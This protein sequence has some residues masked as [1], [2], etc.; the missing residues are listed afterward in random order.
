M[1]ITFMKHLLSEQYDPKEIYIRSTDTSE[2]ISSVLA[3]LAGMFPGQGKSIWDKDLLL[4]TFPIHI[5]PEESD[6]ILGQKKSCPTYEESL[7]ILKKF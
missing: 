2:T 1:G 3:N 4:P 6:E 5:V 7:D